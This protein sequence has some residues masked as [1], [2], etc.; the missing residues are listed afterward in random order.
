MEFWRIRRLERS[1][2][3]FG[4]RI[5]TYPRT[6][7][8]SVYGGL[9]LETVQF[10]CALTFQSCIFPYPLG[11][12]SDFDQVFEMRRVQH[13]ANH[14]LFVRAGASVSCHR[15]FP[16]CPVSRSCLWRKTSNR[17]GKAFELL[18]LHDPGRFGSTASNLTRK[19]FGGDGNSFPERNLICD[20][21]QQ[22]E[23]D[24]PAVSYN[25]IMSENKGEALCMLQQHWNDLHDRVSWS[26]HTQGEQ[27]CQGDHLLPQRQ[28]ETC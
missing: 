23:R 6:R 18:R 14:V 17:L 19:L 26:A 16:A 28:A 2:L 9:H 24:Q 11:M 21:I 7:F 1:L 13:L 20:L 22:T 8:R 12:P 10:A 3:A 27:S 15:S 5:R 25:G 4:E